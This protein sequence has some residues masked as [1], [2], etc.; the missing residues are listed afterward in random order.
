[1]KLNMKIVAPIGILVIGL[2][3]AAVLIAARSSVETE[4]PKAPP[5]LV[6]ALDVRMESLELKVPAQGTVAPRTESD[7]ISQVSGRVVDVSPKFAN[8]GF[9]EKGDVLVQIDPRDY[10]LALATA[11][12]EVAKAQVRY[13][14]EQEESAVA[15]AEWAKVGDGKATDLVLRKPAT[16]WPS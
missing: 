5:P 2:A 10:E 6:R 14:Q 16:R 1:M 13:S 4:I 8:G 11:N 7:L 15:Q 3:S 12:V 9:F